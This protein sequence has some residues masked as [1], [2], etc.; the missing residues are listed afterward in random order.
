MSAIPLGPEG[1]EY[2]MLRALAQA[3]AAAALGEVPVGAVIVLEGQAVGVGFN[4]PITACD[5]SAHAE[6]QALRDACARLGNYRLPGATLYATLEPCSMCAGALVHARIARLV[7]GAREPKAGA[8]VSRAAL[9]DAA[10]LNHRVDWQEGVLGAR[11][12]AQLSGFF[13]A[14]REARR[15][16]PPAG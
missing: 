9:L 8:V 13:A 1:D 7:F 2:W 5:P 10:H 11:C 4:R 12:S 14:R 3:D 16:A 6:I 15:A